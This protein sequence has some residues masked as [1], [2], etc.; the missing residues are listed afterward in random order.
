MCLCRVLG[1]LS[2]SES[3]A[4]P[5]L[6]WLVKDLLYHLRFYLHA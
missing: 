6:V 5:C 2:K 4:G 3:H 1:V